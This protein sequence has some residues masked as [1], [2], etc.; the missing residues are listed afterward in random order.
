M[1]TQGLWW[2]R[3]NPYPKAEQVLFNGVR[4]MPRSEM[5]WERIWAV[6]RTLCGSCACLTHTICGTE[7]FSGLIPW[8]FQGKFNF[9]LLWSKE[10]LVVL[11]EGKSHQR[12][13]NITSLLF[14]LKPTHFKIQTNK[15]PL[16]NP[17]QPILST[18]ETTFSTEN[19]FIQT[20][21]YYL[22][23]L[24]LFLIN[25]SLMSKHVLHLCF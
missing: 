17:G 10:V 5:L 21:L 23:G 18:Q 9:P 25:T 7:D 14:S 12:F 19:K 3:N 24:C 4:I 8:C 2:T 15:N 13:Y 1:S 20:F 6:G 22:E 11:S 16:Q